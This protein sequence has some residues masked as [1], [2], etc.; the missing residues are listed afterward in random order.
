MEPQHSAPGPLAAPVALIT[1][2]DSGIGRATAVRLA[3]AG[4][5]IG[6]TWHRDEEGAQ[7]TA[8][9][10][11]AAGRHAEIERL[12]LTRLPEAA[13]VVDRLAERLGRLDVLVNNS[14][15]GTM[16]PFLDLDL[17]TVREVVDV[18]LVG[19]FLCAQRAAHH[20]IAQGEGGRIINVTSVHEH[21][22]R[23]G[24]ALVLRG[25]GRARAAHPGHGLDLADLRD[26]R[27]RCPLAGEIASADEEPAA[28]RVRGAGVPLRP[29]TDVT[30]RATARGARGAPPGDARVGV[31]VAA[32]GRSHLRHPKAAADRVAAVIAFPR[33]A[34]LRVLPSRV[35][36]GRWTTP[37]RRTPPVSR[38]LLPRSTTTRSPGRASAVA[39]RWA[40]CV[41]DGAGRP[42]SHL[43]RTMRRDGRH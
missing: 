25:Q 15:T 5:D 1:G 11:R 7:Q 14:G 43:H 19:P 6:V 41:L 32:R 3:E 20:M 39:V 10:V 24:A 28:G 42:V 21:Q 34:G 35:P 30:G 4:M 37:K 36:P 16:T 29:D 9:E 17:G 31:V 40:C 33:S 23:V 26:H 22:P 27:E 18:D 8:Y 12:D 2:S 13:G 38:T